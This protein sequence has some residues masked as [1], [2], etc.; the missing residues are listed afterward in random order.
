MRRRNKNDL[1]K[2]LMRRCRKPSLH[3]EGGR[4][5]GEAREGKRETQKL[6]EGGKGSGFGLF[7]M[8]N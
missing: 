5:E 6:W 7:K 8:I 3:G 1:R 2:E 4:R